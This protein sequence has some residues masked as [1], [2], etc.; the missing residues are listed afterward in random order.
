ML[1]KTIEEYGGPF[2]DAEPVQNP[3][4]EQAAAHGNRAL[5]DLAQLTRTG[6]RGI[7]HFSTTATAAPTAATVTYHTSLWG[8]TDT[9]KPVVTKTATGVYSVAYAAQLTDGLDVVED[10]NFTS[11]QVAFMSANDGAVQFSSISSTGCV[12][13]VMDFAGGEADTVGTVMVWL[14]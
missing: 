12:I 8:S 11:G 1:A 13:R 3:Q 9:E 14:R 5:E 2:V 6:T 10:L 4:S 7:V